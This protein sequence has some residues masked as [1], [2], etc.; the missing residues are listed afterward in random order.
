MAEAVDATIKNDKITMITIEK[1]RVFSMNL[2]LS[3]LTSKRKN[4]EA[5]SNCGD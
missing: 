4:S 3:T 1:W 2:S 5:L